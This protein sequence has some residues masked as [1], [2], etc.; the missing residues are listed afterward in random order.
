MDR[1]RG[2]VLVSVLGWNGVVSCRWLRTGSSDKKREETKLNPG[3]FAEAGVG[4]EG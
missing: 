3:G 2:F 1:M 4:R